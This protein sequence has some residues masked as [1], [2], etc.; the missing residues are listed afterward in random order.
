MCNRVVQETKQKQQ[1]EQ[2]RTFQTCFSFH[3]DSF[4]HGCISQIW[5]ASK[6]PGIHTKSY[7][8]TSS[9]F[10]I[11]PYLHSHPHLETTPL[12]EPALH[13]SAL[14]RAVLAL[15]PT[16]AVLTQL[17]SDDCLHQNTHPAAQGSKQLRN[18]DDLSCRIKFGVPAIS[19]SEKPVF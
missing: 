11:L 8:S 18:G 4:S 15:H 19:D 17:T 10:I 9:S 12:M 13:S 6:V 16:P 2:A 14:P 1:T 7:P 3:L 5:G